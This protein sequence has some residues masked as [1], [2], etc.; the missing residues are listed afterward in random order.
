M[1]LIKTNN[2][3]PFFK[4]KESQWIFTGK[5][6]E[7][8]IPKVYQERDLLTIGD[9]VSTLGIFQLRIDDALSA[10]MMILS[11]VTIEFLSVRTEVEDEFEYIVLS[12]EKDSVFISNI[13]LVKDNNLIYSIFVTFLAL[14]KIPPFLTYNIIQSLFDN[15]KKHCGIDLK[16]NHSIYEMIYAHMFRSNEDPYMFYRHTPMNKPPV[17][18]PIHQI[19]HGPIS[20]SARITG[21]YL[22]EGMTSALVD[23]TEH[24]PSLVENLLRA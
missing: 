14:G 18:V 3:A 8:W 20:T 16:V 13:F 17:I 19:S 9:D 6:L 12:L 21:S 2:I 7:V 15:D 5:K 4:R 1:A 22:T 10:T 23:D 24:R 11:R